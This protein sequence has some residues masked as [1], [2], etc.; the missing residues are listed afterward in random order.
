MT[1]LAEQETTILPKSKNALDIPK[2]IDS[3]IP[4]EK[5][6]TFADRIPELLEG[7]LFDRSV[8]ALRKTLTSM[9]LLDSTDNVVYW[10]G[11]A[12]MR[13]GWK[14]MFNWKV[15]GSHKM[16]EYGPGLLISNHACVL[17]PF[18][19]G[20]GMPRVVRWL[21]KK[22]N[23]EMPIFKSILCWFY[24]LKLDRDNP[25]QGIVDTIDAINDGWWVGMF[26]E[27]TRSKE[28]TVAPEFKTGAARVILK[29]KVPYLPCCIKGSEKVIPKNT[30]GLNFS[31]V[32][33]RT[34]EPVYLDFNKYNI[35]KKRDVLQITKEMQRRVQE[36]WDS[37]VDPKTK[38]IIKPDH[39]Q[40]IQKKRSRDLD[41]S[42]S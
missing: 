6:K 38:V 21:S 12:A 19:I 7:N 13:V 29:T 34:G 39:P 15:Y 18:L 2:T 25:E 30:V 26:P 33:V 8:S 31:K 23:F 28:G 10:H 24:T 9:N 4:F 22:E 16:P 32:E 14:A 37:E 36:L 35:D 3:E 5:K 1:Q 42:I 11:R 41:L 27:G 17:D 20:A 40:A